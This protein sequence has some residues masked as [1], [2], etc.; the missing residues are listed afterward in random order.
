[1][2]QLILVLALTG[3]VVYFITTYIPMPPV[4]KTAIYVVCAVV[5]IVYLMGVLG[6]SDVPIPRLR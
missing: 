6:V 4:F 1:M 5:L 3:F 2:L